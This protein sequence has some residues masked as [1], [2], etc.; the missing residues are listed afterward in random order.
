MLE[1]PQD[2]NNRLEAYFR[3]LEAIKKNKKIR[4]LGEDRRSFLKSTTFAVAVI[5]G[6]VTSG[7]ILLAS[8]KLN[9]VTTKRELISLKQ[10]LDVDDKN[11]FVRKLNE[12]SK[13]TPRFLD[14]I[15]Y[16]QLL[17]TVE[18]KKRVKQL[19]E[20][21]KKK[22]RVE[23]FSIRL[24]ATIEGIHFIRQLFINNDIDLVGINHF[25]KTSFLGLFR[26][27]YG[28]LNNTSK[29]CKEIAEKVKNYNELAKLVGEPNYKLWIDEDKLEHIKKELCLASD[30]LWDYDL[31]AENYLKE[32]WNLN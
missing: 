5:A 1:I 23:N 7:S 12:L 2:P 31:I 29:L 9:K 13:E 28:K 8:N 24:N 6:A 32:K 18:D 10:Q 11:D 17:Q 25:Y 4:N 3:S 19:L 14:L 22:N 30:S 26:N 15:N 21:I 16:M 20:N 27:Y